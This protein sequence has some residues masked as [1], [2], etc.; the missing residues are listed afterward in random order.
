MDAKSVQSVTPEHIM[1]VGLGFWAC[2]VE[3]TEV[4]LD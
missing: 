4:C 1:Q 3:E 2:R